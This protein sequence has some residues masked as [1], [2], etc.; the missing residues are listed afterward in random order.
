MSNIFRI[1]LGTVGLVILLETTIVTPGRGAEAVMRDG[2]LVRYNTGVVF[3]TE[4]G[5]EWYAGPDH[6]MNWAEAQSWVTGLEAFGGGWRM[7]TRCE[8]DRL[9]DVGDGIRNITYLLNNSGYWIWSGETP[10]S[11]SKWIFS[12]SYGGEGWSGQAP[13]DGGRALAVR[14][15]THY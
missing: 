9:H 12:F 15:R 11:A 14:I 13:A 10:E 7:P 8:L 4:T 1:L 2:D 5:L 6:G 3:D